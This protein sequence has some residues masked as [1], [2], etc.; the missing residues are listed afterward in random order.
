MSGN[1]GF[2]GGGGP[3]GSGGDGS[4]GPPG[5]NPPGGGSGNYH[6]EKHGETPRGGGGA[7]GPDR[8]SFAQA[9]SEEQK[10][11]NETL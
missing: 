5:G 1:P 6:A 7:P 10:K 2:P 3:D 8:G 11:K 9:C 4:G